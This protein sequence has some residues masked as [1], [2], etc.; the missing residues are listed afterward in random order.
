MFTLILACAPHLPPPPT[1]GVPVAPTEGVV[2]RSTFGV[3]T[4]L[5]RGAPAAAEWRSSDPRVT[6]DAT[7]DGL[8]NVAFVVPT[9]REWPYSLP[10]RV[11]CTAGTYTVKIPVAWT[12]PGPRDWIAADGTVVLALHTGTS[13]GVQRES[14]PRVVTATMTP[15]V[16]GVSCAATKN[17]GLAWDVRSDATATGGTCSTTLADGTTVE[18]RFAILRY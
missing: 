3:G 15:P 13:F 7:A 14:T 6:C 8:L 11:E 10:P 18:R 5:P 9:A 17:G 4:R 16:D 12:P 2:G 1:L